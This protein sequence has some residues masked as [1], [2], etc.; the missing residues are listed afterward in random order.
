MEMLLLTDDTSLGYQ[1]AVWRRRRDT[2]GGE[3]EMV[4]SAQQRADGQAFNDL[5]PDFWPLSVTLVLSFD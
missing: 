4:A 5:L 2:T 1:T 3:W